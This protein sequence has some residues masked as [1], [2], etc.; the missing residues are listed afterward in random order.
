MSECSF[1]KDRW[2]S[3]WMYLI[4]EPWLVDGLIGHG[5]EMDTFMSLRDVIDM[6]GPGNRNIHRPVI[7]GTDNKIYVVL[8]KA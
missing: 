5:F 4:H 6:T 1:W 2:P 3:V 7:T 8:L